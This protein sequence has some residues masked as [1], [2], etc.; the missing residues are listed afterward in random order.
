MKGILI[1]LVLLTTFVFDFQSDVNMCVLLF[2][3]PTGCFL[4]PYLP[5]LLPLRIPVRVCRTFI[6]KL[7]A[8]V[9]IRSGFWLIQ[10]CR[11]SI[12][13][14]PF[15]SWLL[16]YQ[17][18]LLHL[19]SQW[20]D[21]WLYIPDSRVRSEHGLFCVVHHLWSWWIWR[22]FDREYYSRPVRCRPMFIFLNGC[23]EFQVCFWSEIDDEYWKF[24]ALHSAIPKKTK[25]GLLV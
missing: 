24:F 22:A 23:L 6:C 7:S 16:A 15:L 18:K 11:W 13:G 14:A 25:L 9:A 10:I 4:V 8:L 1:M 20:V 19:F 3:R 2:F 17:S 21:V 5:P 12:F